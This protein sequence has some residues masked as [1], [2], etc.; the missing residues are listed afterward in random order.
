V[1]MCK[2]PRK[3]VLTRLPLL[4]SAFLL[5]PIG[6]EETPPDID[7]SQFDRPQDVAFV[8]YDTLEKQTRPIECCRNT[9]TVPTS[10]CPVGLPYAKIYAFVTQTTSGEVAVVDLEQQEIVDQEKRIPYNSFVPVGG[11]PSDIQAAWEGGMVYTVNFETWDITA[12]DVVDDENNF[13]VIENPSIEQTTSIDIGGPGARLAIAN[14]P[15]D[16]RDRFAFVTQPTENRLAV[17]ALDGASCPD[18]EASPNGC[19]LAWLPLNASAG[20]EIAD[21]DAPTI[22]PWSIASSTQTHSLY[23]SG[24]EGDFIVEIAGDFLIQEALTLEKPGPLSNNAIIRRIDTG[25]FTTR[26]L[27]LEPNLE[28]W[29]YAIESQTGGIVIID[30]VNEQLV[31]LADGNL[32]LDVPGKALA[33]TLVRLGEDD[34]DDL[35]GPLTFNGSFAVVSTTTGQ[36]IVIDVDDENGKMLNPDPPYHPHVIRSA[37]DLSSTAEVPSFPRLDGPPDLIAGDYPIIDSDVSKFAV[38][39]IPDGGITTD[40]GTVLDPDL[41]TC[42]AAG[43]VEFRPDY[44]HGF[45]FRCDPR[46]SQRESWKIEWQGPIGLSGAAVVLHDQSSPEETGAVLVMDETRNFCEGGL[47]VGRFLPESYPGDLFVI[48]SGPSPYRPEDVEPCREIYGDDDLVYQITGVRDPEGRILEVANNT[49]N[50]ATIPLPS[51]TCFTAAF[52]YEIRA[53]DHWVVEGSVSGHLYDGDLVYDTDAGMGRCV[54]GP[55][56][57]EGATQRVWQN[58]PF[59]N[60]YFSFTL[61]PGEYYDPDKK[62]YILT[63]PETG[64]ESSP[65]QLYFVLLTT[66]GFSPLT[67]VMGNAITDL[68]FTPDFDLVL[69]DQASEGLIVFDLIHNFGMLGQSVN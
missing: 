16:N 48:T 38:F 69:V 6:C 51:P 22:L 59:Q 15:P 43:T 11:Q 60:N 37:T 10:T 25:G 55:L 19:L 68:D 32:T 58:V 34:E 30:L 36:I 41:P 13:S 42:D 1:S 49:P 28:R 53:F 64:K 27:A 44:S 33:L 47:N 5:F 62:E 26:S 4:L 12:I 66:G 20:L 2:T 65:E 52:K 50:I 56:E 40:A 63:D 17:V 18:R 61:I 8:C 7:I 29:I 35:P 3:R 14:S 24:L 21:P 57:S 45:R 23:V 67:A 9:G 39:N 54:P 46:Q 31:V